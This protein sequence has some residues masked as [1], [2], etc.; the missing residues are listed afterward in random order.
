[1]SA[2]LSEPGLAPPPL[3]SSPPW[4]I[5]A[6][7]SIV[8]VLELAFIRQVPAEVRV[9]SYFTNLVLMAA[10]FGLGLGCILQHRRI[11]SWLF[12]LGVGLTFLFVYY[13]RG[14]VVY[15]RDTAVH[16]W[17]QY[18]EMQGQ[19]RQVPLLPAAL[20]AF[21]AASLPFVSLGQTLAQRMDEH[22][23]AVAYGWDIAGSLLGTVAFTASSFLGVPP[24]VWVAAI[25]VAWAFLFERKWSRRLP[26]LAAGAAF[27]LLGHSPH[28]A[29]WSPYYFIQYARE[30]LG[31]RVWVNSSFHQ[32]AIDFTDKGDPATQSLMRTKWGAPY[33]AYVSLHGG[34][35]PRRVLVLGAG[36]GN[37]VVMALANGAEQ[38]VAVEIDPVILKLGRELNP[39]APYGDPRVRAVVDDARHYLRSSPERFD[40]IVFGTLDSQ[41]L[42][43]GH[44]NLRLENYV[45]TR[46]ALSDARRLLNEGGMAVLHYSV[47]RP[48]ILGRIY[49]TVRAA[50]G[51]ECVLLR[52]SSP[53]L[54]NVTILAGRGLSALRDDPR[55]VAEFGRALPASD[56]WPF[57][58]LERP[59]IAPVYLQILFVIVLL[60]F[61]AFLLVRRLHAGTGAHF[62]FLALGLGFSL[63]ESA[64]VVRF[65]LLFGSTW[66][67]NAVVFTSVL[68]TIFVANLVVL[69]GRAPALNVSFALLWLAVLANYVFPLN[70][71]FATGPL[72]RAVVSGLLVGSPVFFAGLC[73]SGLFGAQ[74]VTGYPLGMNLV[75]AM[76]GGVLEYASMLTGMRAVWLMV[77]VLYLIAWLAYRRTASG[78]GALTA[79]GGQ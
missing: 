10:F 48:W 68:A 16:Y 44:A 59:T 32:L 54:F 42:L 7:S 33:Q 58:Y 65:A 49:S 78:P 27:A 26:V 43:S 13:A 79:A 74:K 69:R 1:V 8:L 31:L 12:P 50:F 56:D 53:A 34:A 29:R 76:G 2:A 5:A 30:P 25:M 3:P 75:G 15:D 52:E 62:D 57:V 18:A 24:W 61:G 73:F 64:A 17:L 19:A 47:F 38:V 51:D 45:Y 72:A 36:T 22:P 4:R 66:V 37:D 28:P 39:S 20:A 55:T 70:I 41:S 6:V 63:M 21:V 11:P 67:V 46:E 9:I 71:L 14:I 35:A 23:R 60:V 40:I 77:L